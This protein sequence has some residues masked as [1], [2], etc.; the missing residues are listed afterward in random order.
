MPS[1]VRFPFASYVNVFAAPVWSTSN[2]A[3]AVFPLASIAVIV[4]VFVPAVT[5]TPADELP[6]GRHRRRLALDRHRRRL[7]HRP[8]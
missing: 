3:V 5:G 7:V 6:R 4:T 1:D 8:R 2:T